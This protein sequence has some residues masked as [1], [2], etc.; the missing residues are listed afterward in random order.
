MHSRLNS[1]N[2]AL[3]AA[4]A[5]GTRAGRRPRGYQIEAISWGLEGSYLCG[6][7]VG[8]GKSF[9]GVATAVALNYNTVAFVVPAHL[10]NTWLEEIARWAGVNVM[11]ELQGNR[12]LRVERV[13]LSRD[14]EVLFREPVKALPDRCWLLVSHETVAEWG[15]IVAA[16][17]EGRLITTEA[18]V[19]SVAAVKDL[20]R[21]PELVVVDEAHNM[22]SSAAAR[23]GGLHALCRGARRVIGMS[24]TLLSGGAHRLW[25]PLTAVSTGWGSYNSFI[26]RYCGAYRDEHEHLTPGL[27][28]NTDE[29][30]WRMQNLVLRYS[31][32]DFAHELPQETIQR[33]SVRVEPGDARHIADAALRL[34]KTLRGHGESRAESTFLP[35]EL[36]VLRELLA[37]T[38]LAD[39]A[40]L[41]RDLVASGERVLVWCW[42]HSAVERIAEVLGKPPR[43][44]CYTAHGGCSR[45]WVDNSID[46]WRLNGGVLAATTELLGTGVDVL[47]RVC[48][49]QV[50]LEMPWRVDRWVQARG[51]LV[52]MSQTAPVMTYV[53]VADV[54]FDR[55]FFDRLMVEASTTDPLLGDNR[56]SLVAAALG[57]DVNVGLKLNEWFGG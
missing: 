44:T 56:G 38:K 45:A 34:Q 54:P 51:R 52:R 4:D 16:R 40:A 17:R 26:E 32:Q 53:A 47:A 49:M 8:C 23:T 24:A 11:Y 2:A 3:A 10:F 37:E 31:A 6:F 19:E 20:V 46:K 13:Y 9:V 35:G 28:T 27:P 14:G 12:R 22:G 57:L 41:C 55:S 25:G 43:V 18:A 1:L 36:Q 48:R 33:L 30:R 15:R 42:H 7:S 21:Q 50:F 39:V 5:C 29:L